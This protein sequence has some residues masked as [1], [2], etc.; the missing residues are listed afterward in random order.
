MKEE[1]I[2]KKVLYLI[3]K[4][5]SVA[6]NVLEQIREEGY[7]M[8]LISSESLRHVVD[9]FPEENHFFTLRNYQQGQELESML[10]IFVGEE[11]K[12]ESIKKSVRKYTNGFKNVRGFMFSVSAEDYEGSI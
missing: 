8:T 12:V 4:N 3:L 9:D 7:N 6:H 10:C 2:M 1:Q 11:D 5:T